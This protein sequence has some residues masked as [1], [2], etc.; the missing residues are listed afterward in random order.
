[1]S[2]VEILTMLIQQTMLLTM[3]QVSVVESRL[4]KMLHGGAMYTFIAFTF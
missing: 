3:Q 2:A 1:M 4:Q